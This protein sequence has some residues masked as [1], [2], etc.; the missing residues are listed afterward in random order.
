[1]G[2][3]ETALTVVNLALFFV[4]ASYTN[5]AHAKILVLAPAE[6]LHQVHVGQHRSEQIYANHCYPAHHRII[7]RR[8]Y[9]LQAT[10]PV[11]LE[12]L[13]ATL[14]AMCLF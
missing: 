14:V 12:N 9:F 5:T 4:Q 8:I 3:L 1:M 7:Q 10:T 6:K 2:R 13:S 11:M